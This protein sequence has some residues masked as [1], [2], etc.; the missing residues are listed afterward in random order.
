MAGIV[1]LLDTN[2]ISDLLKRNP[3][4]YSHLQAA[5]AG[6]DILSICQPVYYEIIRG[7]IWAGASAKLRILKEEFLPTIRW[8]LL[9]DDDW[10]QAAQYWAATVAAGRQLGDMDLLL[11][12]IA[13]RLNAV[14]VTSDQDFDALPIRRTNW[15]APLPPSTEP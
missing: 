11:A 1:Y 15:R 7:L 2:V 6:G 8:T 14:I 12:A 13:L 5:R 4:V 10:T 9:M 3:V